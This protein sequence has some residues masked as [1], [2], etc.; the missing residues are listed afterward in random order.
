MEELHGISV[1][2]VGRVTVEP[3]IATL[4]I[5]VSIA[6]SDLEAI[7]SAAS[8]KLAGARDHLLSAGV[9][10][11]DVQTDRLNV[12]TSFD[13]Q[14]R[15]TTHY[16]NSGLRA[17]IR[18]LTAAPLIVNELFEIV[19][20]GLEM[21]GLTFGTE[22]PDAGADEARARAVADARHK[23]EH[24]AELAGVSLGAVQAIVEGGAAGGSG[25]P[26][27]LRAMAASAEMDMPIEAGELTKTTMVWVRWAIAD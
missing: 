23:A 22:D 13:H 17:T 12:H 14:V 19:G 2:G 15:Q 4:S 20:D 7:R 3:D 16:L 26:Q 24:L 18:D 1:T 8:E 6:G 11:A 9:D 5:G 10:R 25:Q 21:H 27:M